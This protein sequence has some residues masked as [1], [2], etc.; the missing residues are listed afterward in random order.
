MIIRAW[1]ANNDKAE[2]F[3]LLKLQLYNQIS[4][5][6]PNSL[7]HLRGSWHF[8]PIFRFNKLR[9]VFCD[10]LSG[11]TSHPAAPAKSDNR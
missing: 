2:E 7:R 11:S 10:E 5:G 1:M 9:L 4:T 8:R 3:A 6:S